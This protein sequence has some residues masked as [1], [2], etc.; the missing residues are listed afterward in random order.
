MCQVLLGA[1]IM[2]RNKTDEV[3]NLMEVISILEYEDRWQDVA[4]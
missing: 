2:A 3:F 1:G 4:Y